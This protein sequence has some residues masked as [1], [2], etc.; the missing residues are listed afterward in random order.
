MSNRVRLVFFN[1]GVMGRHKE[2]VDMLRT[3][4]LVAA[5]M[6]IWWNIGEQADARYAVARPMVVLR[7]YP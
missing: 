7:V 2:T 3:M 4:I 6:V 1:R 5:G